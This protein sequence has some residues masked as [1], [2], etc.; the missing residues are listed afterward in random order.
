MKTQRI[1]NSSKV[2]FFGTCNDKELYYGYNQVLCLLHCLVA[3][4]YTID[5]ARSLFLCDMATR[6]YLTKDQL[7]GDEGYFKDTHWV[8]EKAIPKALRD[9]YDANWPKIKEYLNI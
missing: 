4:G 8:L 7:S 3:R 5:E 1:C 6:G 2:L 9:D